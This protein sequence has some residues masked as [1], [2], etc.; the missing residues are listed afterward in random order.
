MRTQ[1]LENG[2]VAL[3]FPYD[4]KI[5]RVIKGM[6]GRQFEPRL[7]AWLLPVNPL[8]DSYL[9]TLAGLGF[10]IDPKINS[11]S[12]GVIPPGRITPVLEANF[13]SDLPLYPY[14]REI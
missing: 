6:A 13:T 7:K 4:E 2:M 10:T 12:G 3:F 1:L 11:L 8:L 14:Q 9:K 5:V